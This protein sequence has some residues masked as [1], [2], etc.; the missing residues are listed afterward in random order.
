MK[1]SHSDPNAKESTSDAFRRANT[2]PRSVESTHLGRRHP[3]F[4]SFHFSFQIL[5]MTVNPFKNATVRRAW[6]SSGPVFRAF[7][8]AGGTKGLRTSSKAGE[9]SRLFKYR[10]DP[11]R[12]RRYSLWPSN[13]IRRIV[14]LRGVAAVR[15][16]LGVNKARTKTKRVLLWGLRNRDFPYKGRSLCVREC[17]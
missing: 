5:E 16:L 8:V 13:R 3:R 1:L 9:Q 6:G 10:N 2:F 17:I 14:E 7:T 4:V 15:L 12:E 11:R